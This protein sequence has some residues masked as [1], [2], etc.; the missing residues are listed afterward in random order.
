M[1][2]KQQNLRLDEWIN[3]CP[4]FKNYLSKYHNVEIKKGKSYTLCEID[5][6]YIYKDFI[7]LGENKVRDSKGC[8]KHMEKQI[9]RFKKYENFISKQFGVKGRPFY[10]FYAHFENNQLHVEYEGKKVTI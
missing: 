6:F 5:D 7:L 8:H 2:E 4:M 9:K 10:Y 3:K 1:N